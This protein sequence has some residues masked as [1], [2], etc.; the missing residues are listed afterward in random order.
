[1]CWLSH[2]CWHH[3]WCSCMIVAT[4]MVMLWWNANSLDLIEST[5]DS[6]TRLF[7]SMPTCYFLWF[8]FLSRKL[9]LGLFINTG[10]VLPL[11]NARFNSYI[12]DLGFVILLDG[13]YEDFVYDWWVPCQVETT[14]AAARMPTVQMAEDQDTWR[15][16]LTWNWHCTANVLYVDP[17]HQRF[18]MIW[19]LNSMIFFF[20]TKNRFLTVGVSILL[21][22]V[23]NIVIPMLPVF[24]I[25]FEAL[26]R[27]SW[28]S[29]MDIIVSGCVDYV[30]LQFRIMDWYNSHIIL[31]RR[32][33]LSPCLS[34]SG[35]S[36]LIP[37]LNPS[38]MKPILAIRSISPNDMPWPSPSCM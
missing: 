38:W 20:F 5:P 32:I 7:P 3:T 23:I 31:L 22:M 28:R 2:F 24:V 12:A 14:T 11:V 9:F 26:R 4:F 37:P 35:F 17:P 33:V 25:P 1:M 6:N 19:Y 15:F 34:C 36:S 30:C 27:V 21:T 29:Q 18:Y 10:L 13:V 16:I 8:V